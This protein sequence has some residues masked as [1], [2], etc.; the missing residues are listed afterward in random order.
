MTYFW[1]TSRITCDLLRRNERILQKFMSFTFTPKNGYNNLEPI[2]RM[3]NRTSIMLSRKMHTKHIHLG[4]CVE[5][6]AALKYAKIEAKMSRLS[7]N[8]QQVCCYCRDSEKSE[9]HTSTMKHQEQLKNA[10]RKKKEELLEKEQRLRKTGQNILQDIRD[11]KEKMRER[12]E[13]ERENIWTIPNIL[14][15]GR[16]I[17]SP[18]LGYLI[19]QGDFPLALALFG[20][21]GFTDMLDGWIA[22][23]FNQ[24]SKL[25]SFLDPLSDKILVGVLF[26]TLTVAGHI[27]VALTALI[28]ARDLLLVGAGFVI[29]YK[30][31]PPPRTLTRYFDASMVTAQLQ[32]TLISKVNTV[33]QLVLVAAV[34]SAPVWDLPSPEAILTLSYITAATTVASGLSYALNYQNTYHIF[35]K[36]KKTP[37]S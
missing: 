34:M 11:T 19:I 32:P 22:R 16:I 27:S 35:T 37:E 3:Q 13:T 33:V 28:I 8:C 4:K 24:C 36:K 5:V 12:M 26:T 21:A 25:G 1:P 9:V 14:C 29:R 20:L 30:S 15:V 6:T 23:N 31:L 18:F 2:T 17:V 10:F 7:W